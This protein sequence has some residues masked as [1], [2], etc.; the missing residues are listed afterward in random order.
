M[1]LANRQKD[2][3]LKCKRLAE[4][5]LYNGITILV[6]DTTEVR[7]NKSRTGSRTRRNSRKD[8]LNPS[9]PKKANI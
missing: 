2:L 3:D 4:T 9:S 6:V 7:V 8:A 5:Y 1:H